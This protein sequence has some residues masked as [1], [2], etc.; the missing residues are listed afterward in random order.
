MALKVKII[1]PISIVQY[2]GGG[3][4]GCIWEWNYCYIDESGNFVDIYSSGVCGCRNLEHISDYVRN[5]KKGKDY[6][7]YDVTKQM[8]L[9]EFC[10]K[11]NA[12]NVFSVARWFAKH[13]YPTA[14]FRMECGG[15]NKLT[16]VIDLF[17][18]EFDYH[19]DGGIGIVHDRLYCDNCLEKQYREAC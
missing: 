7:I 10:E 17:A 12:D 16:D 19:G 2:S 9:D 3:Y 4:D 8:D 13:P 14:Q 5:S 1:K 11:T 15:C 18:S 6:F